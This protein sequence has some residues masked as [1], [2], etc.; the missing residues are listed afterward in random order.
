MALELAPAG[1]Q[2]GPATMTTIIIMPT[3]I[4]IRVEGL[5]DTSRFGM[6]LSIAELNLK[7][8]PPV[9]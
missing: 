2:A 5:K 1:L 3:E 6:L 4:A 9:E 8:S 7:F